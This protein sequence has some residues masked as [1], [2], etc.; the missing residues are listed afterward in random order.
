M[1]KLLKDIKRH[2]VIVQAPES[3]H[4]RPVIVSFSSVRRFIA[5]SFYGP[6]LL[7]PKLAEALAG[8]ETGDGQS[9]VKVSGGE[10]REQIT[11]EVGS[12][13]QLGEGTADAFLGVMCF[14]S[15]R[16][17]E[18]VDE[19]Q[20][21]VDILVDLSSATGAVM[22]QNFRLKC[23]QWS[24]MTKWRYEGTDSFQTNF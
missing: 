4:D 6:L 11:C 2:P 17:K 9:F 20:G 14:E 24:V 12:S 18:T 3:S 13:E 10:N 21:Y 7:F 8:L 19:F 5:A 1:D 22:A 23:V 16:F 15:T